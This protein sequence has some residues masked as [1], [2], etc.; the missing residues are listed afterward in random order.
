MENQQQYK[1]NLFVPESLGSGTMCFLE[2]HMN[3]WII[4]ES[5]VNEEILRNS[6]H[7]LLYIAPLY[8]HREQ[9]YIYKTIQFYISI[10][11]FFVVKWMLPSLW[12]I[13]M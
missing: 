4:H 9:I 2:V 11:V 5:A 1:I 7:I 6:G 3:Q 10:R 8:F 13:K 12:L